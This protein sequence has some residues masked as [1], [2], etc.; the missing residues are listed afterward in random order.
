MIEID[1]PS[2]DPIQHEVKI[3][4][5]MTARQCLCIVPGGGLGFGLFML[6]RSLSTD[7]AM[8]LLILCVV[9]AVFMGWYKPYNMKFEQFVQL[10]WFNT[11]VSN[12]KRIYKTD[13]ADDSV[14]KPSNAQKTTKE[15]K[16]T[17]EENKTTEAKIK[18]KEASL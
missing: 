17:K 2:I 5:G 4:M 6:T 7:V 10:W 14:L 9:P 1:I 12:P 11:F 8:A 16:D 3:F 15:D 13:N 18:E